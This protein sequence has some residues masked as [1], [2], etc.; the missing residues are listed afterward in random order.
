[1]ICSHVYTDLKVWSVACKKAGENYMWGN[2]VKLQTDADVLFLCEV[3][4]Y[5]ET[6]G[7]KQD[8]KSV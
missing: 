3:E 1:M 2:A 4:V 5:A 6:Y 8:T 7:K